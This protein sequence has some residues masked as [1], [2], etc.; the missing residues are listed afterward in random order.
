[1]V[2]SNKKKKRLNKKVKFKRTGQGTVVPSK[3]AIISLQVLDGTGPGQLPRPTVSP[4]QFGKERQDHLLG[5]ESE[6]SLQP[7]GQRD[8]R[9]SAANFIH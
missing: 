2:G 1:M 7:C 9:L 3:T 4:V 5:L 8:S 6:P